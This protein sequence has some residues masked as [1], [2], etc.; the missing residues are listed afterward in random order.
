MSR[1]DDAV[2]RQ[3]EDVVGAIVDPCSESA[4]TP[5]TLRE[6]GLVRGVSVEGNVAVVE[7]RLTAPSCPMVPYFVDAIERGIEQVAG[8]D[9]VV[10]RTDGGFDWSPLLV[11]PRAAARR[12]EILARRRDLL[13]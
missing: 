11:D 3:L 7:M 9:G 2:R 10:L 12:N 8:I 6:M 13:R 5:M 1:A 4:G